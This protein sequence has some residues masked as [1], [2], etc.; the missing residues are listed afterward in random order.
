MGDSTQHIA[1]V[2]EAAI[3]LGVSEGAI[4]KRIR[5][6]TLPAEKDQAGQWRV[7]LPAGMAVPDSTGQVPDAAG[8]GT[9]QATPTA[10]PAETLARL[11]ALEAE[12]AALRGALA[13]AEKDRDAWHAQAQQAQAATDRALQALTNQQALSLPAAAK[14]MHALPDASARP[15]GWLARLFQRDRQ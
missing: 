13:A 10:L 12:N 14:E 4:L 6:G 9:G 5:R 11:A 1:T 3:A 2:R 8:A 15:R 7:S